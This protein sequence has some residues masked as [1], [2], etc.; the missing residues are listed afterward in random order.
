MTETS[1][2][3]K[4]FVL[5]LSAGVLSGLFGSAVDRRIRPGRW[6]RFSVSTP[7]PRSAPRCS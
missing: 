2:V 5:G 4:M 1:E 3:V 7:R 6:C